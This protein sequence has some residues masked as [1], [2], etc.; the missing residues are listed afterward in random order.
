MLS[1]LERWDL[2]KVRIVMKLVNYEYNRELLKTVPYD[3]FLDL[4]V[5]YYYIVDISEQGAA[6]ILIHN[7]YL[8][9]WGVNKEE[10]K[11]MAYINYQKFYEIDIRNIEDVVLELIGTTKEEL[12]IGFDELESSIYIVTNQMKLNGATVML[13]PEKLQEISEQLRSD[14]YFAVFYS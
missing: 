12:G 11:K 9:M 8:D 14:I 5:I 2:A 6:T 10:V 7:S 4:A 13:F 3:K 1:Y